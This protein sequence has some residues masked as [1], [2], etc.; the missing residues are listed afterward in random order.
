MD[1]LKILMTMFFVWDELHS[2]N[3]ERREFFY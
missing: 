3:D 1:R 2:M